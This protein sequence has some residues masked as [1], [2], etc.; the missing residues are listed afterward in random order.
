MFLLRM[1]V[2]LRFP[3]IFLKQGLLI[4]PVF[5]FIF[6]K[7]LLVPSLY[8]NSCCIWTLAAG[9]IEQLANRTTNNPNVEKILELL[10]SLAIALLLFLSLSLVANNLITTV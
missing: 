4:I 3:C 8:F 7:G 5:P 10:E 6:I 9:R 1:P 2:I